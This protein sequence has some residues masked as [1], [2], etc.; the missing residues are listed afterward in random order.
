MRRSK[1]GDTAL[2][3]DDVAAPSIWRAWTR[4]LLTN[5]LNPKIGAFYVAVL[6]QFIPAGTSHLA[7]GVM[8]ALVHDVEGILWFTAVIFGAASIRA[9][10]RRRSAQRRSTARP[11]PP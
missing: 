4:G 5:L 8:L 7:V 6:P 3:P 1:T 10:L 2:G 9:W 11:A